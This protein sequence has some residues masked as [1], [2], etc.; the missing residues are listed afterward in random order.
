MSTA[1]PLSILFLLAPLL[2]ACASGGGGTGGG[3]TSAPPSGTTVVLAETDSGFASATA[4]DGIVRSLDQSEDLVRVDADGDGFALLAGFDDSEDTLWALAGLVGTGTLPGAGSNGTATYD[5]LWELIL[6][7]RDG[8]D[9]PSA[10]LRGAQGTMILQ[11]DLARGTFVGNSRA[12]TGTVSTLSV[13]G[14]MAGGSMQ[15]FVR[16]RTANTDIT[17]SLTGR[18]GATKAVGAFHGTMAEDAM[19][20]G[21]LLERD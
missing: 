12:L 17:G 20:G 9:D 3:G 13:T 16:Y 21:F 11:A 6:I 14:A 2:S 19:T 4:A 10:T 8:T 1:R 18:L 7:D 15:G 5:G